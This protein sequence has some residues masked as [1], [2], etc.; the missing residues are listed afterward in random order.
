MWKSF[1]RAYPEHQ[2]KRENIQSVVAEATEKLAILDRDY[3]AEL[4]AAYEVQHELSKELEDCR[5]KLSS[6]YDDL[7]SAKRSLDQWYSK[8]EGN[9]LG[10]GGRNC[11]N[12]PSSVRT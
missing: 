1:Q 5:H 6:A 7:N 8:A 3:K 11:Q 4:S 9:W 10:N 2:S 12:L